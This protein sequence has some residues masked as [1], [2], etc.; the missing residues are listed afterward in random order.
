MSNMLHHTSQ[1]LTVR[2]VA[3]VIRQS[4]W[5]VRAKVRSGEIP[6]IRV[7]I[8]PRAPIRI[9]ADDLERWLFDPSPK[10]PASEAT[11]SSSRTRGLEGEAA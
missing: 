8:G 4:E 11:A 2:E 7:G 3:E 9:D 5:S 6:S 1:L 10:P